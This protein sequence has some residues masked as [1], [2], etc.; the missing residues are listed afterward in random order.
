SNLPPNIKVGIVNVGVAG[1]KIELFEKTNYES[2][3][4]TAAPWMK[5]I[6]KTYDG[7]PYQHL[8]DMAKLAQKDGVIKGFLLHQGESNSGDKEWPNKVKRVYENLL[9]DLD[10]KARSEERRVGKEC[11]S[12]W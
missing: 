11:R 10:L 2:Y 3:A 4:S 7:N 12:R 8:V 5:T 6:I 9:K 1:C